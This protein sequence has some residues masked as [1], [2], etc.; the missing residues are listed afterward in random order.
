KAGKSVIITPSSEN[1]LFSN[2]LEKWL[3]A[4]RLRVKDSTHIKY[5]YLINAHIIPCLGD[6]NVSSI[7]FC[8]LNAFIFEKLNNGR[9]NGEG[10]LSASYVKTLA[11]ILNSALT[12]AAKEGYCKQ[13]GNAL[14]PPRIEKNEPTVL[15]EEEYRKLIAFSVSHPNGTSLG[16]LLALLAGLRVGEVCAL[17]WRDVNFESKSI[18]VNATVTRICRSN[19]RSTLAVGPPKTAASKR[20]IPICSTLFCALETM[21]LQSK[22]EYVISEKD[23]FVNP[24]TFEYRFHKALE[25]AGVKNTNFHSLRHSFATVCAEKGM[26]VKSLSEILGHGTAGITLG[27]YVH[28]SMTHKHAQIELL[29][30]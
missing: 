2:V 24:R 5:S 22:S 27:T 26:D 21:R 30:N 12:F 4:V 20:K 29:C 1:S 14:I 19:A 8:E 7:S 23:G 25:S 3:G 16:M 18:S 9:L 6:K 11:L 13:P 15:T 10:G 17:K 28:P